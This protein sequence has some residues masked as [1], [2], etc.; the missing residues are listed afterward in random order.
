MYSRVIVSLMLA[1]AGAAVQ[2]E[3]AC[4]INPGFEGINVAV[5]GF[6][7]PKSEPVA[8]VE[9][10]RPQQVKDM[11]SH[12]EKYRVIDVRPDFFYDNCHIKHSES[13]E[14]T[15]AGPKGEKA[16]VSQDR[17][18]KDLAQQTVDDGRTLVFLCNNAFGKK[19]C[20]RAANAAIT[21]VC[22][23]GI[24]AERVKWFGMG[25][26][27]MHK[28]YPELTEGPNCRFDRPPKPLK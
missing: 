23:W 7:V 19:G 4:Q 10:V 6:P 25:V 5:K 28:A 21:A 1:L 11:L 18:T 15:F 17:V 27:G 16:Y 2:A 9:Y 20:W 3:P 14:Y 13:F 26:P 12:K 8:G 22:D 24:P